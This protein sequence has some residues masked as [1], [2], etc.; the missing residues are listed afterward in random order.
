MAMLSRTERSFSGRNGVHCS[1]IS[2]IIPERR[3]RALTLEDSRAEAG[4]NVDGGVFPLS[5]LI[6]T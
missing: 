3:G 2:A 1:C 6:S 5:N 4:G